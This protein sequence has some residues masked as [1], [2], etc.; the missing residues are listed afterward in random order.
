M[1]FRAGQ[2]ME[3]TIPHRGADSRGLRRIFSIASSPS[4]EGV[5]RFGLN[6]AEKSSSLKAALLKLEPGEI[7]SATSVGGDFLLPTS[8]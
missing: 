5:I 2:Y 4:E 7:V 6:T 8:T 1:T 3:L